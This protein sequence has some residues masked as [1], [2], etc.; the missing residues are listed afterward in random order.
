MWVT[1]EIAQG[2]ERAIPCS[3]RTAPIRKIP[4][5]AAIAMAGLLASCTAD[6]SLH[7]AAEATGLAT[8]PQEAKPFVKETRPARVGFVPVQSTASRAAVR[9]EPSQFEAI[10][11]ELEAKRLSNEAAGAQARAL[12]TKL[13]PPAPA[14]ALRSN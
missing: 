3:P 11:A 10:E 6:G 7:G 14:D 1:I 9:M 8:T 13:P 2:A 4:V 5:F 12:G